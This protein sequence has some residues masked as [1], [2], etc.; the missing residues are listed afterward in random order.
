MLRVKF[1]CQYNR[2]VLH[3]EVDSLEENLDFNDNSNNFEENL[4]HHVNPF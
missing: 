2:I 3:D 4:Y 1:I